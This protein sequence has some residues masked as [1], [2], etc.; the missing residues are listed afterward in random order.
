[1][2]K[3]CLTLVGFLSVLGCDTSPPVLDD[4]PFDPVLCVEYATCHETCFPAHD[5]L[6]CTEVYCPHLRWQNET[7][8]QA[9]AL[10]SMCIDGECDSY[11]IE[12][13]ALVDGE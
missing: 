13:V 1:M 10:V 7:A 12:C 4:E 9:V 11:D 5:I 2:N 3:V 6:R 8:A